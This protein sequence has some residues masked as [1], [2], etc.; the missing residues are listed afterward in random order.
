MQLTINEPEL[1][2]KIKQQS[3]EEGFEIGFM[4]RLLLVRQLKLSEKV[5]CRR[6][7]LALRERL[8]KQKKKEVDK[9]FMGND[10]D[11]RAEAGR[12]NIIDYN[13]TRWKNIRKKRKEK[14]NE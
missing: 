8:D 9:D 12:Q 5:L 2:E 7:T 1:V 13:K 4:V 6:K 10:R 14:E 3:N 11:K